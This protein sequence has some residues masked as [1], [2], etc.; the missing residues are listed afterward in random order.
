V[1]ITAND[2]TKIYG[3]SLGD[4]DIVGTAKNANNL[5]VDVAG[6]FTFANTYN[7]APLCADSGIYPVKYLP[8]DDS[9]YNVSANFPITLT[10]QRKIITISDVYAIDRE[11]DG[12]TVVQ[13]AGGT[14][15]GLVYS[16]PI[17][18]IPGTASIE[19]KD[20]GDYDVFDI[21]VTL[22]GERAVNY[23]LTQPTGITVT[24]VAKDLSLATDIY[25]EQ[26][27][28]T[29]NG[30]YHYPTP[31]VADSIQTF[32]FDTDFEYGAYTD[33]L[34]AGTATIGIAG[35]GNYTGAN[36]ITFTVA[37]RIIDII[38]TNYEGLI[39]S[40]QPQTVSAYASNLVTNVEIGYI[41]IVNLT[42]S[43]DT[44]TDA[45]DYVITV[46]ELDNPN[47]QLPPVHWLDYT[48]APKD[49]ALARIASMDPVTY[50]GEKI[51]RTPSVTDQQR[52]A[53]LLPQSDYTYSYGDAEDNINVVEGSVSEGF[54]TI[55]GIGNYT[56]TKT[57]TF[58]IQPK[59]ITIS[60]VNATATVAAI[61]TQIYT[62]FQIQ[63]EPALSDIARA[64]TLLKDADFTYSYGTATDNI[65][66][67]SGSPMEGT[68][69][70]TGKGNYT[71]SV[72]V[73]FDIAP[74]TIV[75]G[76]T[77]TVTVDSIESLEYTGYRH[78]PEPTVS[79]L[80]R[81]AT[82]VKNADFNYVYGTNIDCTT[83]GT[84]E[85]SVSISGINNYTGSVTV[86]FD[87]T[88][89]TVTAS[90]ASYDAG[91]N[92]VRMIYN[93]GY[94]EVSVSPEG[95]VQRDIDN[96]TLP[97]FT[98]AY[99]D[100]KPF[101]VLADEATYPVSVTLN[102]INYPNYSLVQV[103]FAA[104][105]DP[106]PIEIVFQNHSGLVY[107]G[108]SK[109]VE[110]VFTDNNDICTDSQGAP[111]DLSLVLSDYTYTPFIG[112]A[113]TL[114][115]IK[116]A[117]EYGVRVS[118]DGADK[119]NYT[120]SNTNELFFTV[121]RKE[122]TVQ[123]EDRSKFF[124]DA[125]NTDIH[126]TQRVD[127]GTADGDI[128]IVLLR[129]RSAENMFDYE[130][131]GSY[132]YTGIVEQNNYNFTL[133]ENSGHF[134]INKR[135]IG[136]VPQKHTKVYGEADP[137]DL[138]QSMVNAYDI[139]IVFD[140]VREAGENAGV[141]AIDT[142][143]TTITY[144]RYT[145][146]GYTADNE[147]ADNFRIASYET[148]DW[149]TITKRLIPVYMGEFQ[150]VYGEEDPQSYGY[151]LDA[152]NLADIDKGKPLSEVFPNYTVTR[153]EGE[154]VK[155]GGYALTLDLGNDNYEASMTGP[156]R[157][158][159]R[160]LVIADTFDLNEIFAISKTKV[161]D[162]NN[163]AGAT[164]TL[165]DIL[166]RT[167]FG[168]TATYNQRDAGQGL[169]ISLVYKINSTARVN[170]ELPAD[171]VLT[172]CEITKRKLT[173]S[174][175]QDTATMVYGS[176]LPSFSL[177]YNGFLS[178]DTA[179]TVG[180]DDIGIEYGT[181][182]RY[183]GVGNYTLTLSGETQYA[184]YYLDLGDEATVT[185]T[186]APLEVLP[187]ERYV[188]TVDDHEG[189]EANTLDETNYVFSGILNNDSVNLT[190]TAL[191]DSGI[192]GETKVQLTNLKIDN[193]NYM[194]V[195][196]VLVIDALI[197][198]RPV[199]RVYDAT[200]D[201]DGKAKTVTPSVKIDN[202]EIDQYIVTY[203]GE[204]YNNTIPPVNAGEYRVNVVTT[205][206]EY[207]T[208]TATA[209]LRIRRIFPVITISGTLTQVYGNFKPLTAKVRGFDFEEVVPVIYPFDTDKPDA[210]TY[211]VKA[212]F[213][214]NQNYYP[215]SSQENTAIL[216]ITQRA[217]SVTFYGY[218][219]L[220]YD[221]TDKDIGATFN[222][223][224]EGDTVEP[225]MDYAGFTP[226]NAGTYTVTVSSGNPNYKIVGT[227]TLTFIIAKRT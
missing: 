80:A 122:L 8:T 101:G 96:G 157:L 138:S 105:V 46:T 63:P 62:G 183:S 163:K 65:N 180:I 177:Q 109:Q 150:K 220:V 182:S 43:G 41:D 37:Q 216:S 208:I 193:D 174:F 64:V 116:D 137:D 103:D 84:A 124:G 155:T 204:G 188:R 162:G 104:K 98:I 87:I 169:T 141:Y 27:T 159:I 49:I 7:T 15:H 147:L 92:L 61:P 206:D 221:G 151:E 76:D 143:A 33:N 113:A 25:F 28:L 52:G 2:I 3:Q 154:N 16:D 20:I 215:L 6:S 91:E 59:S 165:P 29:Y 56:G 160:K 191:L 120:I 118:L 12:T 60:G 181:L 100:G 218:R 45:A 171:S 199:I 129:D 146:N 178:G 119:S 47:Y 186:P 126:F 192:P 136:I 17:T 73:S 69:Y 31:W 211:T 53:D 153:E 77:P 195:T 78:T 185:V 117:G 125:D 194:L 85:G 74:K 202:V 67:I 108:T 68:V 166:K 207:E 38:Y 156:A 86:V 170:F 23:T 223:V 70:L 114:T 75:L 148:T 187:G 198:S 139:K 54:V 81:A 203:I 158:V 190:Y 44:H 95:C 71:G 135:I 131:F 42:V 66:V 14:L 93:G 107:D 121:Q 123:A 210:G 205:S 106:K 36:E 200:Y 161:Y 24:I 145:E 227:D 197:K 110:C 19:N 39:Y 134:T 83:S 142:L 168:V 21:H 5:L 226:I 133:A 149:F 88:P 189:R 97:R 201:Y 127:S 111:D 18:I 34:F 58:D 196:S 130:S 22:G 140:F 112:E 26:V 11:Y 179:E 209:L 219:D 9:N 48:I 13:L 10:V 115:E 167:G 222:G 225:V 51:R 214:G 30:D 132:S 128:F 144:Y 152:S 175:V 213:D 217:I 184:N 1:T 57:A 224:L 35:K 94:Q 40:G 172:D 212:G 4:A 90:I 79:D 89:K 50:T 32:V 164:V 102:R 99:P 173:A 55:N 82:L 176:D 72:S